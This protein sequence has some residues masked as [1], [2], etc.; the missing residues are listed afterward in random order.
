MYEGE[1]VCKTCKDPPTASQKN[2]AASYLNPFTKEFPRFDVRNVPKQ[3]EH[4]FLIL[5]ILCSS[6]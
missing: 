4:G 3:Y 1:E 2:H 6:D 5:L